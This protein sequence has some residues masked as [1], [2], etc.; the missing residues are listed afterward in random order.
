LDR[1][2][3]AF[4]SSRR[5]IAL[6]CDWPG[7]LPLPPLGLAHRR[8]PDLLDAIHARQ[9]G[10]PLGGGETGSADSLRFCG[11]KGRPGDAFKRGNGKHEVTR[12]VPIL[13]CSSVGEPA[14]NSAQ[15]LDLLLP[16]IVLDWLLLT[17]QTPTRGKVP[18]EEKSPRLA[19]PVVALRTPDIP[20]R[21]PAK[22]TMDP[23]KNPC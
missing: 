18:Q 23:P 12:L 13:C 9:A 16:K 5:R 15:A 10:G 2:S 1:W 21:S 8:E 6:P 4:P 14:R 17:V 11:V 20:C 3:K 19:T 7:Q 22:A